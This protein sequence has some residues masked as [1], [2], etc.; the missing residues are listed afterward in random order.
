MHEY[1]PKPELCIPPSTHT[2][3]S[4]QPSTT[5]TI[6]FHA[7][8]EPTTAGWFACPRFTYHYLPY[9]LLHSHP[10]FT[11]MSV[12][13]EGSSFITRPV[14]FTT[15]PP[16]MYP[17]VLGNCI[18]S[19]VDLCSLKR[20]KRR[21]KI[22]HIFLYLLLCE[23]CTLAWWRENR[24]IPQSRNLATRSPLIPPFRPSFLRC[25]FE[26]GVKKAATIRIRTAVCVLRSKLDMRNC[27]F[28]RMLK[29]QNHRII[30][31]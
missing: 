10:F 28:I 30:E 26:E 12:P 22:V 27:G 23:S 31:P 3:T 1:L 8:R 21:I 16:F 11:F 25:L 24:M 19:I 4:E 18:L 2:D 7:S 17:A 13:V 29:L 15:L 5:T 6:L 14:T 20:S 9:N